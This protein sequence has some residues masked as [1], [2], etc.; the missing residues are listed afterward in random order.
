MA[1][2]PTEFSNEEIIKAGKEL[3]AAG[4]NVTGFALR[5][6]VGGGSAP[7]LKQVWDE[8][9]SSQSVVTAEQMAE[10]PVEVEEQ[11]KTVSE[12]LIE[13]LRLLAA[14][15]NNRAVKASERRVSEVV[16]SAGEQR[17]QAER[18][19]ADASMTVDDLETKLDAATDEAKALSE[20]LDEVTQTAQQQA[21]ELAQLKERLL[22]AESAAKLSEEHYQTEHTRANEA[23]DKAS[24]LEGQIEAL[25]KVLANK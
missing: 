14:D 2:R 17:A 4:R 7:R 12:A 24:R 20:K 18:E 9:I 1:M 22:A 5:Q 15:L 16:R 6:R 19:L 25:E 21:V 3:Q 10:L 13:R 8:H 11:L 23:R